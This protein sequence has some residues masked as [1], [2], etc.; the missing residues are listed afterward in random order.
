MAAKR[1]AKK[2]YSWEIT[3]IRERGKLLGHVDSPDEKAAIEEA[4]RDPRGHGTL[5]AEAPS[6]AT[7][8]DG[9]SK[10]EPMP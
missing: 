3:L 4:I 7:R 5:A 8:L 10:F 6:R 2:L 1:P 9:C